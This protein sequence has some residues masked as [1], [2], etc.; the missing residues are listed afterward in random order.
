[1][2][3]N[4]LV[5]FGFG[6]FEPMQSLHRE[7]NRLFDDAFR[8]FGTRSG[9]ASQGSGMPALFNANM[10]VSETGNEYRV[11]L[12]LPGVTAQDVD[13]SLDDDVLTIRG[14]KKFE[15]ER[16]TREEENFHYVERSYGSFQRSLRL[17][18]TAQPDDIK[19]SFE[20]GVLTVCVPKS[21]QQERSRRIPIQTGESGSSTQQS[22]IGAPSSSS[23]ADDTGQS[24]TH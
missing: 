9:A 1:M 8:G 19:A 17:P 12:E 5:P 7:M 15:A 10:N 22:T 2:A 23:G 21:A 14:E 16:G 6:N 20:N 4:S 13:I 3:R 18:F 24:A 11:T